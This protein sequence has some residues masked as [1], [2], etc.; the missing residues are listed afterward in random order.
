MMRTTRLSVTAALVYL[1]FGHAALQAQGN[2]P[3][4]DNLAPASRTAGSGQFTLVV[5][6]TNLRDGAK[7]HW[8]GLP[9]DTEPSADGTKLN[10]KILADDIGQAGTAEVTVVQQVGQQTRISAPA[11]FTITS[12]GGGSTGGGGSTPP[13]TTSNPAPAMTALTPV[14]ARVGQNKF[15]LNV[16]GSN[17][18]EGAVVRWGGVSRTTRRVSATHLV[19]EI[20]ASEVTTPRTVQVSVLNPAPGGGT[21][22][23]LPFEVIHYAPTVNSLS[24]RS[25]TVGGAAFTLTV[26]GANYL[27]TGAAVRWNGDS[28]PT[29]YVSGSQLKA[30]VAAS[31]IT[32]T[33]DVSVTVST[34][35]GTSTKTSSAATLSV[36]PPVVGPI[37]VVAL[38]PS[39][40]AFRVGGSANP[41][42]VA[43][44][45][46][47]PL[48][49]TRT[50][51]ATH[52]RVSRN[53]I[54]RGAAWESI[55]TAPTY[56]FATSDTS[57]TTQRTLHFQYRNISGSDTVV[58]PAVS[59]EVIVRP[60]FTAASITPSVAGSTTSDRRRRLCPAG[61]VM[62]G[63]EWRQS[64]L[65]VDAVGISCGTAT[66]ATLVGNTS[67]GDRFTRY[68]TG[69]AVPVPMLVTPPAF[70][71]IGP[72]FL[73]SL[74]GGDCDQY[75]VG[76]NTTFD[77]LY[78]T[79]VA[80]ASIYVR[81]GDQLRCPD[82]GFPI[83]LD[84]YLERVQIGTATLV[85]GV[86]GLGLICAKPE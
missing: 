32:S 28:L 53:S 24:P 75:P 1:A 22:T 23:N 57:L 77:P 42:R 41:E 70:G 58:S 45:R 29:D 27:A 20:S 64:M 25:V 79:P 63:L 73:A 5:T 10:A 39:I 76:S 44:G 16:I 59:D 19:T 8:K 60:A 35:A 56:T 14:Q 17:F 62:T 68:C 7:V 61:E 21:S 50:G 74:M 65:W 11:T 4:I 12:S 13:P 69:G 78:A 48:Y 36:I 54:F 81:T 67:G 26:G 83:G 30:T 34:R 55:A 3:A 72:G 33:G 15:D 43:A 52:W 46:A 49:V 9:R 47:I 84:V 82:G 66:Q 40:T 37:V 51:A 86:K 38:P 31:R 71:T 80:G 2:V 18:V 6:G 85:S